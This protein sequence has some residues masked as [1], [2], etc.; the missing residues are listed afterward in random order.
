V[1][2]WK[3]FTETRV[4]LAKPI[5]DRFHVCVFVTCLQ[6]IEPSIKVM[7]IVTKVTVLETNRMHRAFNLEPLYRPTTMGGCLDLRQHSFRDQREI[8]SG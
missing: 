8:Q 1:N 7:N 2:I 3:P 5:D 4:I 6:A